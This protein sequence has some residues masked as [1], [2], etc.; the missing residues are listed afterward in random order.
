M[1]YRVAIY[2]RYSSELQREASIEDQIRQATEHAQ[3]MG[4]TILETYSDHA[5]SGASM[6]RPGLQKLLADAAGKKFDMVVT[7]S[8]DR[9]S[10]DQEHVAG[11]FKRLTYAEI[12]MFSLSNNNIVTDLDIGIG[13]Y[14]NAKFL[15]DLGVKTR[16]GLR[17]RVEQG[18]SGGGKVYGYD[19]V[20]QFNQA[21]DPV[22]GERTINPIQSEIVRRIFE[23][24]ANGKSPRLIAMGLNKEGIPS[25][26]NRGWAAT[27]ITGKKSKGTGIVNNELF[28]GRMV[29]N[30]NRYI[31]DPL[32][33][34]RV[35]RPNPP[36]EWVIK[37]VPE[38]RII[39]QDLWDNAKVR[40]EDT[41]KPQRPEQARRPKTLLSGLIQCGCCDGGYN[42]MSAT[43]YYCTS[44][45]RKG[46]C[47]NHLSIR[48]DE[49]E[50]A[51]FSA[52]QNNLLQP[53]LFKAFCAEYEAQM[54]ALAGQQS[55]NTTRAT[56]KLEKLQKE[57]S[58]L[59]EAIT[60]GI[61][62]DKVKEELTRITAEIEQT[63]SE[64]DSL[65]QAAATLNPDLAERYREEITRLSESLNNENTKHEGVELVRKVI[66]KIILTPNEDN[67]ALSIDVHGNL[68]GMLSV[69]NGED[70]PLPNMV[71]FYSPQSHTKTDNIPTYR[72]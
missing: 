71:G 61:I 57:E 28:I 54:K 37:D 8:L 2:A 10:R 13:G 48:V 40:Q 11:I 50:K 72:K 66:D 53:E 69:A 39:A 41:A 19:I 25:P 60:Q 23:E 31:K 46:T 55:T 12:P 42:K 5:I 32:T 6:N 64:L 56:A 4:W 17:G 16:R 65:S 33:D 63:Q 9:I 67:T 43:R 44:A 14:M 58:N 47:D 36:E 1:T 21:G 68:E 26:N 35:S 51:A 7:E 34:R 24:Y 38:L 22:R 70:N 45:R 30:K 3:R 29:W 52:V 27:T 15:K 62:N 18:K 49:L 59:I 20:R